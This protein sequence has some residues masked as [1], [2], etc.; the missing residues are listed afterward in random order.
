VRAKARR[1]VFDGVYDDIE[2]SGLEDHARAFHDEMD[3][4]RE[5]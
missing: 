5:R 3:D 4:R 2:Y 1:I